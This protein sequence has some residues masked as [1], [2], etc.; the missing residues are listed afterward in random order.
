MI[1]K[2]ILLIKFLNKA[3]FIFFTQLNGSNYYYLTL[4]ILFNINHLFAYNEIVIC[5]AIIP[6]YSCQHYS[7]AYR[8]MVPST[9]ML[10]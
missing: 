9:V 7:F 5:I 4:I 3:E 10:Y 1:C 8:E 6:N 2:H